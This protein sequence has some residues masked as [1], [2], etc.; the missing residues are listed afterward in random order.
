MH[1]KIKKNP[2]KNMQLTLLKLGVI[3]GL[4]HRAESLTKVNVNCTNTS[5][6]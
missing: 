2:N 1:I 5:S 4:E 3:I 6:H